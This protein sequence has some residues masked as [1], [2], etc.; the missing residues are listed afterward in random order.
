ME[1]GFASGLARIIAAMRSLN[2]ATQR[3]LPDSS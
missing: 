3:M 1:Q 2:S